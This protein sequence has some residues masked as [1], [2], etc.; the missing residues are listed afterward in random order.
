MLTHFDR[1][2]LIWDSPY[3]PFA[4]LLLL[5][6]NSFVN[7]DGE[8]WPSI[9]TL[10]KMTGMSRN[11]VIR[12]VK[13]LSSDKVVKG[14]EQFNAA[15]RQKSNK[16]QIDFEAL[17]RVP[18]RDPKRGVPQR[19]G[20][21]CHRETLEGATER[22]SE[23]AT[24]RPDLSIEDLS[25]RSVQREEENF[26]L[27]VPPENLFS[28]PSETEQAAP[29]I[30][31]VVSNPSYEAVSV[32]ATPLSRPTQT[33]KKD[34]PGRS[35]EAHVA[36]LAKIRPVDTLTNQF[37]CK[38]SS[39]PQ[40]IEFKGI[41][42]RFVS[43]VG[44]NFGVHAK[45]QQAWT[46]V[47]PEIDVDFWDGLEAYVAQK[48]RQFAKEGKAIG[49]KGAANWLLD[50]EWQTALAVEAM[51]EAAQSRGIDLQN[52]KSVKAAAK[53]AGVKAA[54]AKWSTIRQSETPNAI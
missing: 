17:G 7:G 1:E 50:R 3:E 12:K 20:G 51:H 11:S 30:A 34:V 54:F 38:S 5:S 46:E 16:Y 33:E 32:K 10:G 15:G 43:M 47:E 44:G 31:E 37:G 35:G 18:Q 13:E 52:P 42:Q 39:D 27:S 45:A 4:K 25:I 48:Q 40:Y 24:E 41:Y 49:V 23:G 21:G 29:V 9:E 2:K 19:D 28:E 53:Q 14:V 36:G 8:C 22:P 26:A 6:L